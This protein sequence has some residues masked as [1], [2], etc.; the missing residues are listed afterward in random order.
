MHTVQVCVY[1]CGGADDETRGPDVCACVFVGGGEGGSLQAADLYVC[2]TAC[3]GTRLH[4][5]VLHWQLVRS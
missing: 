3:M 4:R 1:V 2:A 5:C